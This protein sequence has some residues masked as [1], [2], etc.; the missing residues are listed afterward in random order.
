MTLTDKKYARLIE[1]RLCIGLGFDE[2]LILKVYDPLGQPH[3]VTM[4]AAMDALLRAFNALPQLLAE[5]RMM[6]EAL[7]GFCCCDNTEFRQFDLKCRACKALDKL[8]GG[9][10]G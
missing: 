8:R 3:P 4:D 10:E 1:D 5:H 6:V 7:E 2:P 9:L